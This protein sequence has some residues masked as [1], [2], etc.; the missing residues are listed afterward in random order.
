LIS[1]P[2][3]FAANCAPVAAF[4]LPPYRPEFDSFDFPGLISLLRQ[5]AR[6]A[7]TLAVLPLI[8]AFFHRVFSR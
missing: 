4:R 5:N 3:V 1:P 6:L 8:S 7:C 2:A